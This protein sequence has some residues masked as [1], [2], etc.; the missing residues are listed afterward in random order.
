MT[1]DDI[2]L[3]LS[4]QKGQG[5]SYLNVGTKEEKLP[6]TLYNVLSYDEIKVGDY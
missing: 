6:L 1:A 4:G 5:D 2:Y 3:L